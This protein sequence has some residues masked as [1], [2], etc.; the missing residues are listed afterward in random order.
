[1]ELLWP[2]R[3]LLG[4][5][6]EIEAET[7]E[8]HW[9][10]ASGGTPD[11]FA[12]L[13]DRHADAVYGQCLRRTGSTADAE[14]LTSMTFLEA[15]RSRR[16]IRFVEGSARPWLFV[17]A[18]NLAL[19]QAR[20][21]RRYRKQLAR[22]PHEVPTED[23][24]SEALSNLASEAAVRTVSRALAKLK[25]NE[26]EVISLCDL[27]GLSYAEAGQVLD[28]PV[29]TVRSRLSRARQHLRPLLDPLDDYA[30]I[31]PLSISIGARPLKDTL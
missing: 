18:T 29:G 4:V 8:E 13:F 1:M 19:N 5:G 24:S 26:Q 3:T 27:A 23:A 17:V 21:A 10:A 6:D 28:V 14:D 11:A 31:T 2:E 15:W 20:A 30:A 22:L 25:R 7:D 16:R 12:L 9:R